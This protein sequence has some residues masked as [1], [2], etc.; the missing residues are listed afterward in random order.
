MIRA[1]NATGKMELTRD[2][3]TLGTR[4]NQTCNVTGLSIAVKYSA[5]GCTTIV[6]DTLTACVS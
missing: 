6:K 5:T 2:P 4:V 3:F 1:Y